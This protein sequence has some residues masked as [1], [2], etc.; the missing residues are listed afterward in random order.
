MEDPRIFTQQFDIQSHNV[1]QNFEVSLQ[2]LMGCMQTTA[3]LH[4]DS[5]GMGW[6]DLHAKGCFWAIYRM[7]LRIER[8]PRKYDRITV[9]TW[10]NPPQGVFQPRSFE[11]FNQKGELVLRAQSLW[12][13]LDDREFRPLKV[14]EVV[15]CDI[16]HLMGQNDTFP[17]PLKVP[18]VSGDCAFPP[19]VRDVLYSDIDSNLHVNNTAYARWITDSLP[20]S[21]LQQ[22]RLTGIVLN[23]TQ[24]ARMGVRY[25]VHTV[26]KSEREYISVI[27]SEDGKEEYCRVKTEWEKM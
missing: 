20:L 11:V 15:G 27:R 1:S 8:M 13:V 9:H 26:Q 19:A 23:Y 4:V 5:R 24:Q 17:I 16:S 7:G 18:P 21:F 22:H 10:A 12:L 25:E 6:N 3:D 14:E 2:Y